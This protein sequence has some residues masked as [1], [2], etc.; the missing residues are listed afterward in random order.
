MERNSV[1]QAPGPADSL[2]GDIDM[3]FLSYKG[4]GNVWEVYG[5]A[6]GGGAELNA[7]IESVIKRAVV[8]GFDI[9]EEVYDGNYSLH[10]HTHRYPH[11]VVV[12]HGEMQEEN[13][14]GIR[15]L[16]RS[17]IVY[18]PGGVNHSIKFEQKSLILSVETRPEREATVNELFKNVRRFT[19]IPGGE[20]M[21]L[22]TRILDEVHRTGMHASV[23]LEGLAL[24]L[25]AFTARLMEGRGASRV[26]RVA[27]EA[28]D[29]IDR[30]YGSRIGLSDVA[31]DLGVSPVRLAEAFKRGYDCT[32]GDYIRKKRVQ[33]AVEMLVNTPQPLGDIALES[34]FCDQPHL[35]RVFKSLTGTTPA[36]FRRAHNDVSH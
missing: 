18:F 31:A 4:C 34:G 3:G 11:L 35:V 24:E 12:F 36:R 27:L 21:P 30:R 2:F 17:H 9:S 13:E 20:L 6:S 8:P 14:G 26:P 15:R 7:P 32:V 16:D 23:A 28:K 19:A 1:A 25:M 10:P 5:M 33:H 22:T 29:V